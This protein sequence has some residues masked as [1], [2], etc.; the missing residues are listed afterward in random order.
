MLH[1]PL[2]RGFRFIHEPLPVGDASIPVLGHGELVALLRERLVYSHGGTFLVTGFRGVGKTTLVLRALA[3]AVTEPAAGARD[4]RRPDHDVLLTV[5]LSVAR[6]MAADQLLFAVVRRI[7]ETLD[8]QGLFRRLPPDIQESLLLAYTRTSLSFTQ[9]H[10]EGT[11][12]GGTLGVGLQRGPAPTLGLTGKRTRTRTT[13]AAFLAYSETDVEHDLVRIIG[14]LSG[15]DDRPRPRGP[16]RRRRPRLRI[17]PV[18]VLDEIDKLTDNDDEAIA[19]LEKLLGSLKNVLTARGAH[20][21]LVAGPDLHDR[22]L[23]DADRGNGLYESVFAWRMYVPCLWAAPERLV[24][25]LTERA[26]AELGLRPEPIPAA[27]PD[28]TLDLSAPEGEPLRLAMFVSYLRFKARG[29]PRRLLQ[30]FNSLITWDGTGRPSLHLGPDDWQRVLFYNHLD[31]IVSETVSAAATNVLAPVPID[32]DRWRLGGYHVTEWALRSR[33]RVFTA[34]DV[35]A[36]GQ[37]DP[38]LR[39]DTPAVERL[40]R[41]LA[42]RRVL[43]VVSEPG[44][45]DATVYGNPGDAGATRYRLTDTYLGQVAGLARHNESERAELR[46]PAPAPPSADADADATTVLRADRGPA[47]APEPD[48]GPSVTFSGRL[49]AITRLADRYEVHQ[50]IGT[51]G[52]GAV[53]R[54]RDLRTGEDVAIKLLHGGLAEDEMILRRFRREGEIALRVRHP[55]IV[56]T[57]AAVE[58]PEPALVMEL[59][60]G[61]SLADLLDEN[62]TLAT[63]D[64]IRLGRSLGEALV[65]LDSLRLSRVDLKPANIIDHPVR[66]AVIIDLGIA[67]AMDEAEG[68]RF[69]RAG[70]V[71]GTP[72]YMAPEQFMSAREADI[73]SDLY[74]LGAVMYQCIMGRPLHDG[75]NVVEIAFSILRNPVSVDGLPVSSQLRDVLATCLARDPADRYQEPAAFLRA[76]ADTPEAREL[77]EQDERPRA[78]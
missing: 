52:M 12:R 70:D 74:S 28:R 36:R 19:D 63:A 55:N 75:A 77:S 10:S 37:L 64:V 14:L 35:T 51:G 53:Y 61:P 26:R 71:V 67:R 17:H 76:L 54:G 18:I 68:R 62:G 6:R 60:D 56:R 1:V 5:H 59:V 78:S 27:Q 40:L 42:R 49:P 46:L 13:E 7:F 25:E 16:L 33:G 41:H 22:A 23:T 8:D 48:P 30:E 50:M 32:D 43:E 3:E 4:G 58:S 34:E 47:P 21:I 20:F 45:P 66:G 9:T 24:K 2:H 39:M 73:R 38:L 31:A 69:T 44:R 29:V 65:H 72:A 57:I 11:E 15:R